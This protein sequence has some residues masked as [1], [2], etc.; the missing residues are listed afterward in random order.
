MPGQFSD[1]GS[2]LALDAVTGAATR[3]A[4]TTVGIT[5]TAVTTGLITTSAAHGLTVG[6]QIY[7]FGATTSPANGVYTVAT[8]PATNTFTTTPAISTAG[9]GGTVVK[10]NRLTYLALATAQPADN[11]VDGTISMTEYN[12]TGYARQ[13]IIWN[14]PTAPSS[15]TINAA[16]A[17]TPAAASVGLSATAANHTVVVVAGGANN[18]LTFTTSAAQHNLVIGQRVTTT[19]FT[20]AGWNVT[21][22]AIISVTP[23][24]FTVLGPTSVTAS[25]TVVGTATTIGPSN[26]TYTTTAAHNFVVG[27]TVNVTG[28][29]PATLNEAN[30]TILS[31]PSTTTFTIQ[32]PDFDT[33]V[34]GGTATVGAQATGP[35][36][37]QGTVT[38]GPFTAN[39]GGVITHAALVSALSGTSGDLIAWWALDTARTPAVNDTI[40]IAAGQLSLYLN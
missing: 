3:T 10:T 7:I 40:T 4:V 2:R 6:A 35:T 22:A 37:A 25:P 29:S 39:T 11:N 1:S 13:N 18:L 31:V 8:T 14:A 33:Y 26:V 23:N 9:T 38:F 20:A 21:N 24:T 34:S 15:A 27:Q 5:S 32:V 17:L 28:V 12:A 19:G 16:V 36:A 30:A